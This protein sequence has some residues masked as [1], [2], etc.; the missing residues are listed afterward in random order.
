[1]NIKVVLPKSHGIEF[2]LLGL[3]IHNKL[4]FYHLHHQIEENNLAAR[5]FVSILKQLLSRIERIVAETLDVILGN[6][7][8][9]PRKASKV[10]LAAVD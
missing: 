1:M 8:G 6:E 10:D 7:M 2:F 4:W 3:V 9:I 5:H